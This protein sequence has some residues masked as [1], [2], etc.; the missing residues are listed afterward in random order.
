VKTFHSLQEEWCK[1]ISTKVQWV[2]WH[3]DREDRALTRDKRLNIEA[4]LLADKRREEA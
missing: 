4:N 2:K 3:A 1:Y